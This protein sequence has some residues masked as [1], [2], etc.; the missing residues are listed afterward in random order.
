[1][2]RKSPICRHLNSR[3]PEL[4]PDRFRLFI[5]VY[6]SLTGILLVTMWALLSNSIIPIDAISLSSSGTS[7]RA[8]Y[9]ASFFHK[10][11]VHLLVNIL[12]F[13]LLGIWLIIQTRIFRKLN[14]RSYLYPVIACLLFI[15]ILP[16][17]ISS[18]LLI[19]P[20]LHLE[21]IA[22]FSGIIC[23]VFG[24]ICVMISCAVWKKFESI[25]VLTG[26]L[27]YSTAVYLLLPFAEIQNASAAIPNAAHRI[28]FLYGVIITWLIGAALTTP[29]KKRVYL[30]LIL[31]VAIFLL[32]IL[33]LG[34]TL[35]T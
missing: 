16:I 6:F 32:P 4:H 2:T 7:V 9:L 27:L 3:N 26:T 33:L 30:Y 20:M 8:L 12:M 14:I 28:G 25:R 22:G 19:L 34:I 1:M 21:N 17:S 18:A 5:L 24:M 15:T 29:A 35:L 10:E 31:L 23:A 13:S 11:P